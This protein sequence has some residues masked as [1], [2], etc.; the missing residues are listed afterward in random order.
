MKIVI[1]FLSIP[2]SILLSG[3]EYYHPVDTLLY[4]ENLSIPQ[5]TLLKA[6]KN[7]QKHSYDRPSLNCQF[8][9]S[10]SNFCAIS[11]SDKGAIKGTII[12]IDRFLRCN[13][14]AIGK[15]EIFSGGYIIPEDRRL[16][17]NLIFKHSNKNKNLGMALSLL[18]GLGKAYYGYHNEAFHTLKYIIPFVGLSYY[19]YVNEYKITFSISTIIGTALWI[20]DIYG[21]HFIS[22]QYHANET[23][24]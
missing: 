11:I 1:I 17:D 10:C 24:N 7:W 18:P 2:M 20:S 5:V 6:I 16:S 23:R 21:V 13:K 12:G 19:S 3:V 15:Y 22:K 4:K 9:P 8:Y 14:F